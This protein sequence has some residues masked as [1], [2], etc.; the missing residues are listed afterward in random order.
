MRRSVGLELPRP[1]KPTDNGVDRVSLG[2][3][4]PSEFAKATSAQP[5]ES[6]PVSKSELTG[7]G[8]DVAL[9]VRPVAFIA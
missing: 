8:G 2:H 9:A 3:L 7:S 4:T 6:P 1:V 5:L